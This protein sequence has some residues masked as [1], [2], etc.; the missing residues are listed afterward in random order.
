MQNQT[1]L[2]FIAAVTCRTS[3]GK[4]VKTTAFLGTLTVVILSLAFSWYRQIASFN[5]SERSYNTSWHIT[6][7]AKLRSNCEVMHPEQLLSCE[8]FSVHNR[9]VYAACTD[10]M[11]LRKKYWFMG[12]R[13]F[14]P[15]GKLWKWDLNV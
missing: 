12:Q 3:L 4:M 13:T 14:K 7:Q 8:K 6:H 15:T 11:E 1:C 2:S 10:N 5:P 9:I